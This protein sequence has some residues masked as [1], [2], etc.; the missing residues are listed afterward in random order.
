MLDYLD[1]WYRW[2]WAFRD[3]ARSRPCICIPD[4]HDVYHGN[5]WGAGGRFAKRQDDG[6]YRMPASFVKMVER[7]Q[8]SHL[9]DPADPRPVAQGIGVYFTELDYAGLSF[10]IL[11]DRKFKSSPSVMIPDG[12]VVNGW[13]QNPDFDPATQA[14]VPG[15]VLLGQRQLAFLRA[16]AADWSHGTWMKVVLSQTLFANVATLPREARSD[17]VVPGLRVFEAGEYPD[18]DRRVAD[19]DSNGWPQTGR[20]KALGELRRG[21]AF[22]IA[23]DQHLG[24]CIHYGVEDWDDAGFALCVPSIANTWP[25]RWFPPEP[26]L[27]HRSGEPRYTG[28]Y[29]D[30]FGNRMRVLAVSNPLR[31]GR[32]PAA[33]HDRAPGYGIVRFDRKTREILVECWPRGVDPGQPGARQYPGWPITVRQLDNY[34]RKRVAWLPELRVEGMQDPVV[35]VLAQQG[36]ELVYALRIQGKRFKPFVFREGSYTLRIGEPG[37]E[38]WRTLRNL[39]ATKTPQEAI[40]V[41][42]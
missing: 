20:N 26:G 7:T 22:H 32:Q 11:E 27:G 3:L 39:R 19:A 33:L 31:S 21:F 14:D 9:P 12:K 13:F 23:G 16:W 4:D 24:S 5:L 15:A 2:C 41:G 28:R 35:Q 40:Q 42:F 17:N 34:G 36:G 30:G 18:N 6:G 10:A 1:K 29:L 25:R 8:V 38:R 37:T